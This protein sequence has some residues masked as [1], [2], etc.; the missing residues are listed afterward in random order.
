M[1]AFNVDL[2]HEVAKYFEDLDIT[3]FQP[4]ATAI[5]LFADDLEHP[6]LVKGAWNNLMSQ[7]PA[8]VN[9]HL[10]REFAKAAPNVD[11]YGVTVS[12]LTDDPCPVWLVVLRVTLGHGNDYRAAALTLTP[13]AAKFLESCFKVV[14]RA[15]KSEAEHRAQILKNQYIEALAESISDGFMILD[16]RGTILYINK[17]GLSILGLG[18]D[19]IGKNLRSVTSFEPEIFDIFKTGK[20]WVDKEFIVDLVSKK[21]VHL[22]KTAI[23]VFD[24]ENRVMAVVD[25]FREIHR[26]QRLVTK[27]SGCQAKFT[28]SDIKYASRQMAHI[29]EF[30]KRVAESTS[31][32]LIYGESG[33]GKEMFAHAIHNHSP[34]R[35]GPFVVVDCSAI[36][37]ELAESELFGYVEGAFTRARRGG[38]P[39]KFEMANGGTVFLD[40]VGE[41]PLDIQKKF[42]R[43]LESHTITRVGDHVPIPVDVRVIAA[44]NRNLEQEVLDRNFRE[45]LFFR[46]NVIS[47]SIP[48]LRERREDIIPLAQAFIQRFSRSM[49]KAFVEL[50]SEAA[51]CL[52]AYPWPGNVRELRNVIERAL[53]LVEGGTILPEHLPLKVQQARETN[54]ANVIDHSKQ[55]VPIL[56]NMERQAIVSA[57]HQAKGNKRQAARILG[58][59]RSTLYEKLRKYNISP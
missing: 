42:L 47:F 56:E 43:C 57:L 6:I 31:P 34:R 35:D 21:N 46:L 36:P 29:V 15:I 26:V 41:L 4:G 3:G 17:V 28:F 5:A 51:Q 45:D 18:S 37:H 55:P 33:T 58:I 11:T 48:P 59:S 25:T 44:T 53:N 1:L 27:I 54:L 30:A 49:G 50:S 8:S 38:R 24:Q 32:V 16:N 20:G 19:V 23:P 7:L 40:E 9:L 14:A 52:L 39:G 2:R 12:K 10:D 13:E 22:V